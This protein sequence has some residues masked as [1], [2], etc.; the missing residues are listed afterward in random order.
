MRAGLVAATLSKARQE[1]DDVRRMRAA[2]RQGLSMSI[3]AATSGRK[4]ALAVRPCQHRAA[5][6][7]AD[8]T[9]AGPESGRGSPP[10]A[11]DAVCD[12]L[13]NLA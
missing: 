7:D 3:C 1:G 4:G 9:P 5:R 2:G 6:I 11:S 8:E 12:K 13:R 10:S